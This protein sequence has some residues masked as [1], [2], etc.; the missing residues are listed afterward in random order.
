MV[1]EVPPKKVEGIE[2]KRGQ[3]KLV[4]DDWALLIQ[5]LGCSSD[6]SE[7]PDEVKRIG[8]KRMPKQSR[9]R[10]EGQFDPKHNHVSGSKP[11]EPAPLSSRC[12]TK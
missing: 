1:P 12:L 3:E 6:G 10:W 9:S 8:Q 5:V 4:F 7:K 11:A 2:T